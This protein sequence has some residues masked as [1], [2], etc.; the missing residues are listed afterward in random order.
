MR[1]WT[2]L[3]APLAAALCTTAAA[4]QP[5]PR[6]PP[7][8]SRVEV[9]VRL[10][11]FEMVN[12]AD[13]YDAVYGETMPVGGVEA[14]AVLRGRLFLAL[15]YERGEVDGERVLLTRPPRPTG[16][17]TELT[18]APLHLTL[19][20][21]LRP[22]ARW[23][24]RLGAGPTLLDWQDASAGE[25]QGGTDLGWHL[26]AGLRRELRRWSLGG[27]LR[28]ST[29]PDAVGEGGVTQFFGD[30]DLGGLEL[31]AVASYRLR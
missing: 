19:G 18:Y 7:P 22:R 16:V 28:Y 6:T 26:A 8:P 25:S 21:V 20:A 24:V 13:S 31:A 30:D 10:A 11:G 29:I 5:A 3:A 4:A 27:E 9:G 17:P 2:L 12:S 15:A 23:Q 14:A 1:P